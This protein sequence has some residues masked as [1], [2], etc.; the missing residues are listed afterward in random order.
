MPLAK[1]EVTHTSTLLASSEV[2][3]L[4]ATGHVRDHLLRGLVG[5]AKPWFHNLRGIT[6]HAQSAGKDF[7]QLAEEGHLERQTQDVAEDPERVQT[8]V[9]QVPEPFSVIRWWRGLVSVAFPL[10]SFSVQQSFYFQ[11][12][13]ISRA[14]LF[15]FSC[16]YI[17]KLS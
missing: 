8:F 4:H 5:F 9:P 7:D 11:T 16:V 12:F 15:L 13:G 3:Y 14:Q 6:A 2:I 17:F 1:S 10:Y